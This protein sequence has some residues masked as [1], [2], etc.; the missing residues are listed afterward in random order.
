MNI[1]L[2]KLVYSGGK[3]VTQAAVD[4]FVRGAVLGT[5]MIAASAAIGVV[6]G[7]FSS[8]AAAEEEYDQLDGSTKPSK[9]RRS[10]SKAQEEAA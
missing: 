8:S 6:A 9:V 5:T 7:M 4:G 3:F 10:K 2:S 1:A